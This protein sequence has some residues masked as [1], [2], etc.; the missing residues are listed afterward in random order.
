VQHLR[1]DLVTQIPARPRRFLLRLALGYSYTEIVAA[2]H[3][4]KTTTNKQIARAKRILRQLETAPE[5][6]SR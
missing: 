1:L 4:S 3:A 2:E 5:R 6:G